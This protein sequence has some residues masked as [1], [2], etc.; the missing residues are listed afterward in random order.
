M[1]LADAT[2]KELRAFL[3]TERERPEGGSYT[4]P[5]SEDLRVDRRRKNKVA[6]ASRKS[7]RSKRG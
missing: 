3:H 7:N 4:R 2:R 1:S 6:K 5:S